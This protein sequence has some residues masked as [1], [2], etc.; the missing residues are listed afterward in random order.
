MSEFYKDSL[1]AKEP[2]VSYFRIPY[3]SL[4]MNF[5]KIV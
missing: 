2:V 5:I 3:I 1:K 4:P